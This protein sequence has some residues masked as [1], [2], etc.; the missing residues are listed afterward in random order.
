MFGGIILDNKNGKLAVLS[1]ALGDG[2]INKS[3]FL[4]MKHCKK[5]EGYLQWKVDLLRK[6]GINTTD[7]YDIDNN[8]HPGVEARTYNN[9]FI[10]LY[11]RILYQPFKKI[12]NRRILNKLDATGIAIWYMDDGGLSIRR[13]NNKISSFQIMLNTHLSKEENDV[14]IQYFKERW[15]V[16]FNSIKNKGKYRLVCGTK[17][18]RKFLNIVSPIVQQVPCMLYKITIQ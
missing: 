6:N 15:D 2:Y 16:S 1:M 4:S 11:R 12:A 13:K 8:G 14:L 9:E 7:V 17:E 5:Q 10:K 3:G 18:G